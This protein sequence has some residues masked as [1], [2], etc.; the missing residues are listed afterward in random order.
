MSDDPVRTTDTE[1]ED[2]DDF[3][4]ERCSECGAELDLDGWDGLCGNCADRAE[5]DEDG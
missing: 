5:P 3:D 1:E 4:Y 2:T